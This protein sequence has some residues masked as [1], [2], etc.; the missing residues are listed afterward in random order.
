MIAVLDRGFVAAEANVE[1]RI[2]TDAVWIIFIT[3]S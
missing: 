2:M 3:K 1:T